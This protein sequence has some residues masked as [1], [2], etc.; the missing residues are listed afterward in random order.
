MSQIK[1]PTVSHFS[2]WPKQRGGTRGLFEVQHNMATAAGLWGDIYCEPRTKLFMTLFP[3]KNPSQLL[4]GHGRNLVQTLCG[5][6]LRYSTEA[7]LG[8]QL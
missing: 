3:I 5:D 7:R 4:S 2:N 1:I 6:Q 8:E